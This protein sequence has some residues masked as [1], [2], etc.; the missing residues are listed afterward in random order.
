MPALT[1]MKSKSALA[2]LV[3][4]IVLLALCQA[5]LAAP[6]G[7][8]TV[9]EV[10]KAGASV[11]VGTWTYDATNHA[12]T[13]APF[14]QTFSPYLAYSGQDSYMSSPKMAVAAKGFYVDDLA[15]WVAARTDVPL[16]SATSFNVTTADNPGGFYYGTPWTLA[17]VD[18]R[19]YYPSYIMKG[20][21]DDSTRAPRRAVLA[22]VGASARAY[23]TTPA[24]PA[25]QLS[26]T[27]ALDSLAD[28]A[29]DGGS[30]TLYMGQVKG[31]STEVNLGALAA[32]WIDSLTFTPAYLTITPSAAGGGG[33]ATVTTDDGYLKATAGE[34]VSFTVGDITPGY[35]VASVAVADGHAQPVTVSEANGLYSF[36][37]PA[38]GASIKVDLLSPSTLDLTRAS[39][40]AIPDQV[41]T[42]AAV[43]PSFAVTYGGATLA[44]DVDYTVAYAANTALGAATVTITGIGDCAGEKSATFRIIP[45]KAVLLA[46]KAGRG[47]ATVTWKRNGGG[48]SG[49]RVAYRRKGGSAFTSAGHTTSLSKV[50][51][52]LRRGRTYL[53]RVCAYKAID[54]ATCLGAWSRTAQTTI[55]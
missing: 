6:A 40:G 38:S 19:Y 26:L 18:A 47:A 42:G 27:S 28:A 20:T 21:W 51:R 23:Q 4:T 44:Q 31:S 2:A 53:F 35:S 33:T 17:D 15:A 39:L 24:N 13:G 36:T 29:G 11:Q 37:M 46:V 25:D 32:T 52:G 41:Y 30:L 14:V 9:K 10:N 12:L 43:T 16:G 1:H 34:P 48:A 22:I 50:V 5:A 3:A 55:R 7:T 45:G 54:G 8:F 49:Y